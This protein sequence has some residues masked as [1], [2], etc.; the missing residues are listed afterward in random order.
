M[1]LVRKIMT[2]QVKSVDE[3]RGVITFLGTTP[4]VDRYGDVV[5]PRGA[6]MGS[7]RANPVFLWAHNYAMMPIGKSLGERT[8]DKGVE[9]D[10]QFDLE[11]PMGAAAYRKYKE[12]FLNA[13]SI[14]FIPKEMEPLQRGGYKYTRWELLELSA[15]P[16]PA[17]P[18]A[19]QL[20][21]AKAADPTTVAEDILSWA[22]ALSTPEQIARNAAENAPDPVESPIEYVLDVDPD[23]DEL[24]LYDAPT[25]ARMGTLPPEAVMES[26]RDLLW[27]L[28]KAGAVLNKANKAR[29]QQ[30]KTLVDEVLASSESAPGEEDPPE[31]E[32]QT[33][34]PE[35][36]ESPAATTA[37]FS[38]PEQPEAAPPAPQLSGL[39]AIEPGVLAQAV[40]TAVRREVARL[41]GQSHTTR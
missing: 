40:A 28:E 36:R 39:L 15:V 2:M 13:T 5:M 22:S 17:N 25:G 31:P 8:S 38:M 18:E 35:H 32:K 27:P 6:E 33:P 14:G 7:Y 41:T 11:D 10:I 26:V 9:F 37:G 24:V 4:A 21:L 16:V 30:I 29:L 3:A 34:P 12:G 23:T 20:A 1:S 19:L